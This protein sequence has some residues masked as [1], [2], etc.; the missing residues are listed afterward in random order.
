MLHVQDRELVVPGQLLAEGEYHYKVNGIWVFKE[1]DRIYSSVIGLVDLR[2]EEI[3]VIPLEGRYVP[4]QGDQVIGV[5]ANIH[6]SGW[7][8]DINSAYTGNLSVSDLLKRRVDL[9]RADISRYLDV[10]DVVIARIKSVD[11]LMRV[12]LEANRPGMGR[13]KKVRLVEMA[14]VKVPRVIGRGGSMLK[15][16]EGCSGCKLVVGQN[17]RILILGEDQRMVD[18]VA[19]ILPMI[20]REAHIPGLTDR[21]RAT[22]ERMRLEGGG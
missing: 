7:V 3:Q 18:A 17:G 4:K 19:S 22:L 10:G 9:A 20:E 2:G 11:E 6:I 5:I 1:K 21:V 14:P 15:T 12:Q 13:V 8:V 16:L